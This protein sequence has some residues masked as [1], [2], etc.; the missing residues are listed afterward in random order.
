MNEG[1]IVHEGERPGPSGISVR[2]CRDA[3]TQTEP[4]SR[5]SESRPRNNKNKI[6][7]ANVARNLRTSRCFI[8]LGKALKV[9]QKC[10]FYPGLLPIKPFG[11]M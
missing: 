10:L 1:R 11:I 5:A 7:R 6:T 3:A 4:H 2:T 9:K 8:A